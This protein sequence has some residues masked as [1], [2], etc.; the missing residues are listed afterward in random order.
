MVRIVLLRF[1]DVVVIV[2]SIAQA[3]RESGAQIDREHGE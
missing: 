3:K 2:G 1:S